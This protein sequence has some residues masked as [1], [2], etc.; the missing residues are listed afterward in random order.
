MSIICHVFFL[1]LTCI[2]F[3]DM[4]IEIFRF[5]QQSEDITSR[6]IGFQYSISERI[7]AFTLTFKVPP[8][9]HAVV[10]EHTGSGYRDFMSISQKLHLHWHNYSGSVPVVVSYTFEACPGC[11]SPSAPVSRGRRIFLYYNQSKKT[12]VIDSNNSL[13]LSR[14]QRQRR[15]HVLPKSAPMLPR[16]AFYGICHKPDPDDTGGNGGSN[17]LGCIHR[18]YAAG[19]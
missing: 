13:K 15:R 4:K 8:T 5:E 12:T 1:N 3:K 2:F 7:F 9:S 19:F 10:N 18:R 14:W 11:P 6:C 16:I 17:W